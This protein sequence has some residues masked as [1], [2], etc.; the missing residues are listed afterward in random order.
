MLTAA[1]GML[2]GAP[3]DDNITG[4]L[5]ISD[6]KTDNGAANFLGHM[7]A[8]DMAEETFSSTPYMVAMVASFHGKEFPSKIGGVWPESSP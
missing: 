1:M 8:G 5:E 3:G 7:A 6:D 2:F 4:L